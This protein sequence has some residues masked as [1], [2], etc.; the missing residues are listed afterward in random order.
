MSTG[1]PRVVIGVPTSGRSDALARLLDALPA[2]AAPAERVDVVVIDN[3]SN[4]EARQVVE[5][6]VAEAGSKLDYVAE[7]EPGIPFARNAC[8]R[9]ALDRD[10]DAL[11][12]IDDDEWPAPGWLEGLL[13][14]WR[15][16]GA[17]IVLGPAKGVL[18]KEAPRWAR[19]SGVFDKDRGLADGAPV[20]TA[21]SYNTLLSRHA[22]ERLGPT[23]D[24]DF[25]YTGSSDHHYFK[26]AAAAEL[27]SVWCPAALVYEEINPERVRLSWVLKRGYRVGTGATRSTRLRMG[28][29]RAGLRIALLTAANLAYAAWQLLRTIRRRWAWVE[30]A[31]RLAIAVGLLGGIIHRYEE[32]RRTQRAR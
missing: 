30:A 28:N 22:L 1:R 13:A 3:S 4:G 25:R 16:T 15:D 19:H 31:R 18:P 29:V 2:K 23:F 24:G 8:V 6:T 26:H 17:D 10:A 11:V 7:P 9:A 32:Y 5:S 14:T 27:R 20:R 21:Y 12:F